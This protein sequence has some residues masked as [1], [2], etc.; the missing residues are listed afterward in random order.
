MTTLRGTPVANAVPVAVTFVFVAA[1]TLLTDLLPRGL[2]VP[3]A[4][5]RPVAVLS[6][7]VLALLGGMALP[8]LPSLQAAVAADDSCAVEPV[9]AGGRHA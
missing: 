7:T 3:V 8:R 6:A 4:P 9:A 1:A 5:L 2:A